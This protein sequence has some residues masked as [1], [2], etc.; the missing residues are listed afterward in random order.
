MNNKAVTE[1]AAVAASAPVTL[2]TGGGIP[3]TII[4]LA[5]GLV[6]VWLARIVFVNR[7]NRRLEKPAPWQETLPITLAGCLIAGAIIWDRELGISAAAFTGL[8]VGW[9]TVLILEFFGDRIIAGMRAAAGLEPKPVP[10]QR[11]P[12]GVNELPANK[13]EAVFD[14]L[15][16]K[17]DETAAGRDYQPP[18]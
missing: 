11:P 5:V 2:A 15:L 8:G 10:E 17:I 16:H 6:G 9:T 13:D 1:V 14:D 4:S 7:E 3:T 18:K 12:G